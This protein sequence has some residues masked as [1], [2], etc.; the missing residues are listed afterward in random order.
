M[1]LPALLAPT[2]EVG[3]VVRSR[4]LLDRASL[5][6]PGGVN[7]A[8]RK[9]DPPLCVR[10]GSGAYVEDLDGNRYI[11]YQAAYGAILLGHSHPAVNDRVKA[12]IDEQVLFGVGT[13]ELEVQV[14]EKVV[15]HVPGADQAAMC[16]SGSEA[17]FHAIR[18]ARAATGR[19]K[20]VK[21]QGCYHGFHDYVLRNVMS[22]PEMIGKRDPVSAG[23]L[24]AAIDATLVCRYNDSESVRATF[25]EH[26]DQIAA[27]IVEPIAHNSPSIM[28]VDNFLAD[29]RAICDRYGAVL[30]FDEIITGY[31]HHLGGYQAICGVTPDLSTFAKAIANGYP[32][33]VVA[34]RRDLLE[35]Y[36]TTATGNV[37]F[38]GTYNG[39][40]VAMAAALATIETLET[41][42]VH[43]HIFALGERMRQGLRQITDELGVPAVIS[44]YGSLYVML[45]MEEPLKS[46]DDVVRNDRDFFVAYRKELVRNGV[47]EMP[48]NIGRNHISYSHTGDDI[49]RTL[50]ISRA[51][52]KATLEQRGMPKV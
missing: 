37:A 4:E 8:R 38:A 13:T 16:G 14:A 52:L 50:E 21:F 26:G 10:R 43:E 33:A 6:T 34:G 20:I 15:Q 22:T 25:A 42:P 28:P 49:D 18:L 23:M 11:D 36:N 35:Q 29:L 1:S 3:E 27:I 9:I 12:T 39:G 24:E 2:S 7:T 46:Y 45:F 40:A 47:L 31:R 30:I 44:G 41:E 51:A 19:Q 5:V 48:E 17:T 32:A